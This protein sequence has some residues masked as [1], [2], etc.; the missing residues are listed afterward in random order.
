MMNCHNTQAYNFAAPPCSR[1]RR[2]YLAKCDHSWLKKK[3]CVTT[4]A[5]ACFTTLHSSPRRKTPAKPSTFIALSRGSFRIPNESGHLSHRRL[6]VT[7]HRLT[8]TRP[9]PATERSPDG[10][11]LRGR[12]PPAAAGRRGRPLSGG[13]R[14]ESS[15]RHRRRRGGRV[16]GGRAVRAGVPAGAAGAGRGGPAAARVPRDD[17]RRLRPRRGR[18]WVRGAAVRRRRRAADQRRGPRV[19]RQRVA[20]RPEDPLPPR[21]GS[22]N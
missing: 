5:S 1:R 13:A 15:R 22:G 2:C 12:A 10:E 6:T 7:A 14:P 18:L 20:A 9:G 16:P 3:R 21:D 8:R 17:G 11:L 19:H 4:P